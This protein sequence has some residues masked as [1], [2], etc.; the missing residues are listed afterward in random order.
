MTKKLI[1]TVAAISVLS[2]G[3]VVATN[4]FAQTPANGQNGVS[5]LIQEIADKFHLNKDDVQSVFTQHQK[6][7]QT[8]REANY[9]NYLQNLVDTGKITSSQKQLILDKHNE[10]LSQM[11]S[12]K[13]NLKTMTPAQRRAQMQSNMQDL[14]NWASQNNIPLQYLRPFGPGKGRFGKFG[15]HNMPTVTP[16]P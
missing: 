7:M 3:L 15:G 4:A 12:D 13:Q 14:K 2:G 9:E 10:L 5:S 8:Q 16:T 11:Q 1:L 6:E